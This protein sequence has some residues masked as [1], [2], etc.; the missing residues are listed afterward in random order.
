MKEVIKNNYK[1]IIFLTIL[2][3]I[4]LVVFFI[5]KNTA[6]HSPKLL[7][8]NSSVGLIE[9]EN[10]ERY[11]YLIGPY[12][13]TLESCEFIE[14]NLI[15]K[16]NEGNEIKTIFTDVK[17]N[18]LDNIKEKEDFYL[19]LEQIPT[20]T[21]YRLDVTTKVKRNSGENEDISLELK[22]N[23]DT[24]IT[25]G[26]IELITYDI[27]G[28]IESGKTVILYDE[29]LNELGRSVSGNDGKI[30]YYK[31]PIG[32][33]KLVKIDENGNEINSKEV[34]V[35]GGKTTEVDL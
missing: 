5:F 33:Y 29:A 25:I 35:N 27:N 17:G 19:G 12:S 13:F 2:L 28:N 34:I 11:K 18:E 26:E 6:Q 24:E 3:I 1:K 21:S 10:S 20:N 16:D 32:N 7:V 9:N 14:S 31:V 23:F 8:N 15:V 30:N 22:I 4:C